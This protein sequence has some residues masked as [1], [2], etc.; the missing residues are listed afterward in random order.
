[1]EKILKKYPFP[2][3]GLILGMFALGNLLQSYGEGIRATIGIVAWVMLILLVV[4]MVIAKD[5][6]VEA[7]KN[8][9]IAGTMATFPMALMV[10]SVYIANYLKNP[11]IGKIVWFIGLILQILIILYFIKAFVVNF[12]IQTVFPTWFV[13]FVGI[14]VATLTAGAYKQVAIGK[15]SFW[16]ALISYLVLLPIVAYRVVK[17]KNIPEPALPTLVIFAAPGSLLLAA[18][19]AP[20]FKEK[21][22]ILVYFLLV[23]SLIIYVYGVTQMLKMVKMNFFPSFSAF[24]FPIVISGMAI[25]LFTKYAAGIGIKSPILLTLVKVEEIIAVLAI[26]FVFA[27]YMEFIF[28]NKK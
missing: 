15:I 23:L 16:F 5:E 19:M 21:N 14:A 6:F 24:T 17:V 13:V 9:V 26:I 1:M 12:K 28:G 20:I 8:P 3:S 11:G 2:I 4:K 18:Y 27:K 22:I 10:G 25:K 7:M